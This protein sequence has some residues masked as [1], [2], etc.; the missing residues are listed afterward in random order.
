METFSDMEELLDYLYGKGASEDVREESVSREGGLE[1]SRLQAAEWI[2]KVR[3]LFP[4]QTAEV[5]EKHALE[6]F[7]MTELLA[8]KEVLEQITPDMN[9]LKTILQLKHLMKGEVLETAKRIA[10]R[11]PRSYGRSS[12]TASGA[13]FWDASTGASPLPSIRRGIWTSKKP[14]GA[15]SGTTMRRTSSLFYRTCISA[16]V[17][18]SIPTAASSSQ[19]TKAAP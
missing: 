16:A 12:R 10:A 5:L 18:G 3:E 13:V 1:K 17:C 2:T 7:G 11:S 9:L 8:D 19:L 4:K 15:T 14:S 6:E